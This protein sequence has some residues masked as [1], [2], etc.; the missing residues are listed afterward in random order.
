MAG[1]K[2]K[3]RDYCRRVNGERRI[4]RNLDT[5]V[6]GANAQ[7]FWPCEVSARKLEGRHATGRIEL[8]RI[9]I[10]VARKL[11]LLVYLPDFVSGAAVA[12]VRRQED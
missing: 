7:N 4:A 9:C 3:A 5:F 6:M 2:R 12:I 10:K 11:V 8:G 1:G